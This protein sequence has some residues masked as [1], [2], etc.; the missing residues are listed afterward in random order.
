MRR[1][2]RQAISQC[3]SAKVLGAGACCRHVWHAGRAEYTWRL[4]SRVQAGERAGQ[5]GYMHEAHQAMGRHSSCGMGVTR[6]RLYTCIAVL[7][8][9]GRAAQ[10]Q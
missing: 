3:R 1:R 5:G 6:D 2:R 9:V 8:C 4:F 10:F 7:C